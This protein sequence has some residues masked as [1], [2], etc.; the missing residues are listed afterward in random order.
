MAREQLSTLSYSQLGELAHRLTE[1][2][3]TVIRNPSLR[4]DL[5]QAAGAVSDLASIKFGVEEIA[6][7]THDGTTADE[8]LGLIGREAPRR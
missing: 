7:A 1:S 4:A 8:L 5:H 2:A 6:A 3:E